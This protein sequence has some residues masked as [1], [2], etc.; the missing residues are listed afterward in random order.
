M[1]LG[2][3]LRRGL[4]P[5]CSATGNANLKANLYW[6]LLSEPLFQFFP[7]EDLRGVGNATEFLARTD[8]RRTGAQQQEG[9]SLAR[10]R[11]STLLN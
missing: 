2:V 8:T 1:K 11:P 6:S 7:T 3:L 4:R 9:I 5:T 10:S